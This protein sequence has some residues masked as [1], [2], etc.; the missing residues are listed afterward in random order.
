MGRAN[1]SEIIEA[2]ILEF[3]YREIVFGSILHDLVHWN[4][5]KDVTPTLFYELFGRALE[6]ICALM[7]KHWTDDEWRL[8]IWPGIAPPFNSESRFGWLGYVYPI[9]VRAMVRAVN[10]FMEGNAHLR[11]HIRLVDTVHV[12]EGHLD[13]RYSDD[14]HFGATA[15]MH[16]ASVSTVVNDMAGHIFF[17]YLCA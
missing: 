10:D 15:Q 2:R 1:F 7:Q 6:V 9:Y 4:W 16:N 5:Y 11:A 13:R 14:V 12:S 8:W 17:N 3:G